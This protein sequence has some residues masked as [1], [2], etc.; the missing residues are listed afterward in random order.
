M[1]RCYRKKLPDRLVTPMLQCLWERN[2]SFGAEVTAIFWKVLHRAMPSRSKTKL[3]RNDLAVFHPD[4][5]LPASEGLFF[6]IAL[7]V[8]AHWSGEKPPD[9]K[10]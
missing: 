6:G 2:A 9:H 3:P 8:L 4:W 7:V 1:T 10:P 5:A